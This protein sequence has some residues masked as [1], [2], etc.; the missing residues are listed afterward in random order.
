MS[1]L[2]MVK[3]VVGNEG[4]ENAGLAGH[5]MT[6]INDPRIGGISGLMQKFHEHG[7]GG[8]AESWI[9]TGA[10]QP[11]TAEQITAVIGQEHIEAIAGKIGVPPEEASAKLAEYLP[12]LIDRLTPK[13]E[14][15]PAQ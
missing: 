5:A 12:M 10:N 9:G 2:D 14:V 15:P 13:G 6:L 7:L 1:L 8:V 3:G 11:I 4:L